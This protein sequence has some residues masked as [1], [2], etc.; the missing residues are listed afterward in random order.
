MFSVS[1][2]HNSRKATIAGFIWSAMLS[3]MSSKE[4]LCIWTVL[5]AL[6]KWADNFS[7]AAFSCLK[8]E[9]NFFCR[10]LSTKSILATDFVYDDNL[11][12][13]AFISFLSVST[14]GSNFWRKYVSFT[15]IKLA[16][17]DVR[18]LKKFGMSVHRLIISYSSWITSGVNE[19]VTMVAATI[20]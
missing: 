12:F 7:I 20:T 13:V 11:D 18:W 8:T 5:T 4:L 6:F 16:Y 10:G 19:S 15:L 17:T 14:S 1:A 9:V 2:L 3:T